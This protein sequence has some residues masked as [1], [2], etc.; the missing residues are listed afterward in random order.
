MLL[1][2]EKVISMAKFVNLMLQRKQANRLVVSLVAL[3]CLK[4]LSGKNV[5]PMNRIANQYNKLIF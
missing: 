3:T 2:L 1:S 5:T 4:K